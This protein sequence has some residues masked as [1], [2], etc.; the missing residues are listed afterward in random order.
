MRLSFGS[1]N[2]LLYVPPRAFS[3]RFFLDFRLKTYI[4]F[5]DTQTLTGR[6]NEIH[7]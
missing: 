4:V 2:S 1:P 7:Y 5:S 3:A 6:Y